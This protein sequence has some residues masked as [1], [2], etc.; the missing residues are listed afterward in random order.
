MTIKELEAMTCNALNTAT[1]SQALEVGAQWLRTA[2]KEAP[3]EIPVPFYR[4]G[5]RL[6]FP[7][8]PL[9]QYLKSLE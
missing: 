7:R 9:I 2:A 1:A 5:N 4:T 6:K 8:L 3:E